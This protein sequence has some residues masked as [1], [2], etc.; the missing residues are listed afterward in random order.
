[1][2]PKRKKQDGTASIDRVLSFFLSGK[3][4]RDG[5]KGDD[6]RAG[7][8]RRSNTLSPGRGGGRRGRGY[9]FSDDDAGGGDEIDEVL[10][11]ARDKLREGF[12]LGGTAT[13]QKLSPRR[14]FND[15][16]PDGIG[17]VKYD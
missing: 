3:N 15:L 2:P 1:M 8:G 16:D 13:E 14:L 11:D 4:I 9:F 5:D 6:D 12:R 7:N 17:E 10:Q